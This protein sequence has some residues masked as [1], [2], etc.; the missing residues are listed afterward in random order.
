TVRALRGRLLRWDQLALAGCGGG[1]VAGL[2][3][4]ALTSVSGG[5]AGPGR[6]RDVGPA[7]PEVLTHAIAAFGVWALVAALVMGLWRRHG[8]VRWPGRGTVQE[9]PESS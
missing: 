7:W 5:A 9:Q 3:F 4:A 2:A 1:I 6:L 8:G